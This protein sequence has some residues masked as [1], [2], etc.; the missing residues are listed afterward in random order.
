[1]F[2]ARGERF[3]SDISLKQLEHFYAQE[4]NAK[5]KIRLLCAVLRKKGKPQ[6][7]IAESTGKSI[8][9]VS[10]ILRRFEKKGVKGCYAIK[11]NGQPRKLS[12]KQ[13]VKLKK[14]VSQSPEKIGLPFV[15]WTTKLVQYAI[16]KFFSVT[17]T[18]RQV[19]NVLKKFGLTLQKARPEHIKANKKL[20]AEFKKN[21]DEELKSLDAMDM[22]SYFWT[23]APSN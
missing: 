11:Q 5:A 23:K 14:I 8:S 6:T 2:V 3:L 9:T 7:F 17:Y 19:S 10:D 1:M 16:K 13:R 18:I 22:R 21:F 20:Q 4:Q 12:L 15:L